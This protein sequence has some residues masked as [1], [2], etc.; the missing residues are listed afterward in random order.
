MVLMQDFRGVF[1]CFFFDFCGYEDLSL[2]FDFAFPGHV[3]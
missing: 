1:F 2:V 3:R